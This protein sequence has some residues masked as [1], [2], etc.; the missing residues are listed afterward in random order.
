[1]VQRKKWGPEGMKTDIEAVRNKEMGSYK[2]PTALVLPQTTLQ[3]YVWIRK[4]N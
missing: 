2:A 1:M 4:T 3:R